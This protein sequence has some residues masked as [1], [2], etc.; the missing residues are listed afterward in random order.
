MKTLEAVF[1]RHNRDFRENTLEFNVKIYSGIENISEDDYE[2]ESETGT[3]TNFYAQQCFDEIMESGYKWLKDWS[4][5]GRSNGWFVLL[6]SCE[7]T[8]IQTKTIHRIETIVSRYFNN[9]S[10]GLAVFYSKE[11]TEA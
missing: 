6:I 9:Y 5:A 1:N 4:F 2:Y 3:Y 11:E 8:E 7:N 10:K